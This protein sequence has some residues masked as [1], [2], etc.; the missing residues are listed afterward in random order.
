MENETQPQQKLNQAFKQH[1]SEPYQAP[2]TFWQENRIM[3]KA[4]LIFVLCMIL[5]IPQALITNLVQDRRN[6]KTEVHQQ[7]A[8]QISQAQKVQGPLIII[9]YSTTIMEDQSGVKKARVIREYLHIMPEQLKIKANAPV[10]ESHRI[11]IYKLPVYE[12]EITASGMFTNIPWQQAGIPAEQIEWG[13]AQLVISLSDFKGLKVQPNITWNGVTFKTI[14]GSHESQNVEQ[15]L[16]I[17]IELNP[18]L[19][20][21]THN[22]SFKIELRGTQSL[23]FVP[24]ANDN[25]FSLTSNWKMPFAIGN[26]TV[27]LNKDFEAKG[28]VASWNIL[29]I[30]KSFPQILKGGSEALKSEMVGINFSH[31]VDTYDKNM[32]SVKYAILIIVLTFVISFFIE[33]LQNKKVN[34]LQ[35]GLIG[36]ALLVFYTLLL[37]ISEYIGFNGAYVLSAIAVAGLI[38]WYSAGI[39]ESKKLG[40]LT[41]GFLTFLYGF[42]F[43][44]ITIS[45]GSLLLGSI[46]LFLIIALAMYGSRKI[47][48]I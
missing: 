5:L 18:V 24:I 9:P 35:Y 4:A 21:A 13:K 11:G 32:R 36:V 1:I 44:L 37:S 28:T 20:A 6:H 46:G 27:N 40:L 14:M 10:D 25:Q 15:A 23:S 29:G 17:P 43:V 45:D 34:A 22:F 3:L 30:N 19:A 41:S 16:H 42:L 26:H 8:T 7:L 47:K 2:K 39:Y 31:G 48:T 38:G 33:Q 12:S